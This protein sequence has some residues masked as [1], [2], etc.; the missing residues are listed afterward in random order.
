MTARG[1]A[2][3]LAL[4]LALMLGTLALAATRLAG[5]GAGAA[6]VE[7]DLARG[8]AAAEGGAWAALHRLAAVP[9]E[10]RPPVLV[11]PVPVGGVVVEVRATDED[12]R[13][14]LT[15]ASPPRLAA[16]SAAAGAGVEAAGRQAAAAEARRQA[17]PGRRGFA[18]AGEV[19]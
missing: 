6:Q 3:V 2:L 10:A 11:L 8:R 16:M 17:A 13:I 9:P 15:G 12:G 4:W 1:S 7:A 5:S 14:D 19:A 18:T